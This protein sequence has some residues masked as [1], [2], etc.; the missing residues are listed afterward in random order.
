MIDRLQSTPIAIGIHASCSAFM[1]YDS[2]IIT[3]DQ[4]PP[5]GMDHSVVIIGYAS[6]EDDGSDD[7]DNDDGDNDD[8]DDDNTPT[9][10][11]SCK[12]TKWWYTCEE[13]AV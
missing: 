5:A 12:Q 11:T 4:C 2:G 10:I 9:P 8:G 1:Y 3:L 13:S 6:G 7:G